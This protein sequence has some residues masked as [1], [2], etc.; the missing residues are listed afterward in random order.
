MGK[1]IRRLAHASVLRLATRSTVPLTPLPKGSKFDDGKLRY[2][3]V[4]DVAE[5]EMV[6]VL[7]YGAIK[8]E[9]H[10]WRDVPDPNN[11][12]FSAARRH[13]K[14]FRR[15]QRIDPESSLH[16]LAQAITCLHFVLALDLQKPGIRPLDAGRFEES[17]TKARA[18]RAKREKKLPRKR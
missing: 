5:E 7:S 3:L 12:Y 17:L 10:N 4:D 1:R 8:Y 15:K 14:A 16:H 6:A 13:M 18:I 2:D 11:R 9:A